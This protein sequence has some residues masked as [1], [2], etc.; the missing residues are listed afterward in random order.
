M[1]RSHSE[2]TRQTAAF[3]RLH[4]RLRPISRAGCGLAT[5]NYPQINVWKKHDMAIVTALVPGLR[6]GELKIDIVDGTVTIAGSRTGEQVVEPGI[7]QKRERIAGAMERTINFP[8]AIDISRV[9]ASFACGILIL[10]L[11]RQQ[12]ECN[13]GGD[14]ELK[15]DSKIIIGQLGRLVEEIKQRGLDKIE[16]HRRHDRIH[17]RVPRADIYE[18]ANA[19]RLLVDVPGVYD[20][21][22]IS[23]EDD[24]MSID[25]HIRDNDFREC[26]LVF[27]E[28]NLVDY[29]RDFKL[30]NT[31]DQEN[32]VASLRDGLLTV[33][34]PKL[35]TTTD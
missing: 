34:L 23:I 18:G 9:H 11:P 4:Q 20:D 13:C 22:S 7:F 16:P 30:L 25:A 1:T 28:Y 35:L 15:D 10:Q 33:T 21:I 32:I 29:K 6:P 12:Q 26:E 5:G 14:S 2:R 31:I 24:V 27:T 3:E 19:F 8:F 17:K